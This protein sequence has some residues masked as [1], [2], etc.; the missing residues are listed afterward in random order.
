MHISHH[1]PEPRN[2]VPHPQT[3][4]QRPNYNHKR[5]RTPA[6]PSATA[7]WRRAPTPPCG[8][9]AP[10]ASPW[11]RWVRTFTCS[12]MCG[13]CTM[14]VEKSH[15]HVATPNQPTN[16]P[17]T[18]TPPCLFSTSPRA[19]LPGN[20]PS[21]TQPDAATLPRL[22]PWPCQ[23]MGLWSNV[24]LVMDMQVGTCVCLFCMQ[25]HVVVSNLNLLLSSQPL[26]NQ[27]FV[28]SSKTKCHTHRTGW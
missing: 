28:H 13:Y 27:F 7:S 1:V 3:K 26:L 21:L 11:G 17:N 22:R 10:P 20:S 2:P 5:G 18:H 4:S 8:S 14:S 12:F 16:Q 23:T 19:G 15:L 6:S 24:I 25:I 9:S